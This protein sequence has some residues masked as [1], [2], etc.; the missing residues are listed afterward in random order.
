MATITISRE[1]GSLG[2]E[3]AQAVADRLHFRRVWRDVINEAARRAG[4]PEVALATIDDLGL[5]GLRPSRQARQAYLDAVEQVIT[6]LAAEGGVVIVGRAGQVILRGRPDVLH[7]RVMAP[8][9]LRAERIARAHN[10]SMAAA[11]AQVEASDRARR[12]YLRQYYR[13]RW[14]DP[15]L[16]DLIINTER[17]TPKSAADLICQALAFVLPDREAGVGQPEQQAGHRS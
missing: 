9:E 6:E 13:V 10:L 14:D 16:Y 15:E 7:V 5:L 3:V 17:L 4:D 8:A 11:Q 2:T 1:L 12:N